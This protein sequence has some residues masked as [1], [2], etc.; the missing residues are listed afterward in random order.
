MVGVA[1]IG[2]LKPQFLEGL[3]GLDLEVVMAASRVRRYSAN[4][5]VYRQGQLA[6]R[7][8][9]L[10]DGCARYFF[11][12]ED[13]RKILLLWLA[14]GAMLGIASLLAQ[15]STYLAG[16]ETVDDSI[17]LSWDRDTMRRFAKRYPVLLENALSSGT[18]FLAWY[19]AHHESLVCDTARQRLAQV[20]VSLAAGIGQRTAGGTRL[21]VTNEQLA[22]AANITTYTASRHLSDWQRTGIVSKTRGALVVRDP[23]AL[24]ANDL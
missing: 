3:S 10:T 1:T 14:P 13:G 21:R 19:L 6:D 12:T 4:S 20:L 23:Q 9:L 22:N 24:F 15:P 16:L 5:I 11:L 2:E 17:V 18:S 7:V 8:F